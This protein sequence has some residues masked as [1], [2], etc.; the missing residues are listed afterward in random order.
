MNY[1][2]TF[3]RTVIFIPKSADLNSYRA[4]HTPT[5]LVKSH[6]LTNHP[7]NTNFLIRAKTLFLY[8]SRYQEMKQGRKGKRD[9]DK[10]T[11]KS[12]REEN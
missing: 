5:D 4:E 12:K 10:W 7:Y 11:A 8:L 6:T 2:F 3:A 9:D 1:T